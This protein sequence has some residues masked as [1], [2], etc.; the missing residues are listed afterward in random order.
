MSTLVDLTGYKSGYLTVLMISTV[1]HGGRTHWI[2]QCECG[3]VVDVAA[4]NITRKD[5]FSSCGCQRGKNATH[6]M[7]NTVEHKTWRE[8]QYRCYNTNHAY[9]SHYGGRGITVCE[10]WRGSFEAFY[11]DMGKRPEGDY[12]LDRIDNNGPYSPEN[13][14]WATKVEQANNRRL[15]Q[16]RTA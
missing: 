14:R 5:R 16:K 3:N 4:H 9:Y 13:C 11:A 6:G 15:P 2:C 1:R 10:R 8:M 12:S 7:S